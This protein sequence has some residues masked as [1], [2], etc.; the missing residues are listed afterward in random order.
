MK[1]LI[2]DDEKNIQ[3]LLSD[4]VKDN[5][6]QPFVASNVKEAKDILNNELIQVMLL[7]VNLSYEREGIDFLEYV[8]SNF[9]FPPEIIVITGYGNVDLA[10]EAIKK[11]AYDFIEKPPTIE[12]II[13][14]IK[15]ALEK[16]KVVQFY[17]NEEDKNALIGTSSH[18]EYL[19][20]MI[21]TISNTNSNVLITGESGVGKELFAKNLHINS[22]RKDSPFIVVNSA[23]LPEE[24]IEAELFGYE[25]GAF[26][27]AYKMKRG[28]FELASGGTIFL[29]EI[30]DMSLKTQAK[31]LRAIQ[32]KEIER[33]GGEKSIP[34]DIRIIAATNKNIKEL[35]KQGEFR[36][37]L[38]YRL[39]VV[40]IEILP[41][42]KRK[43]DIIPIFEYY[44]K[45]YTK[46]NGKTPIVIENW[47]HDYLLNQNWYGNVRELKNFAEKVVIFSDN[48]KIKREFFNFDNE[49]KVNI[50]NDLSLSK[51][52]ELFEKNYIINM[53]RENDY[54]I[55]KTARILGIDRSNFFKKLKKLGIKIEN[56][57]SSN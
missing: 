6:W 36:E 55:S 25:K 50:Q 5:G 16:A 56:R 24:L 40:E 44:L 28:K 8:K 53:L 42:R 12:R 34:V 49:T 52:K 18:I 46:E 9:E 43:E 31:I 39:N 10:V 29:D 26:T 15:H 35:V 45:K 47:L 54:N 48:G 19:K 2:V 3:K 57:K 20:K 41:L 22:K 14:S 30:G 37:D 1:I 38:Y 51:A 7:D 13:I 17:K 27:N 32:E 23:A 4:I 11:G 21:N 33:I